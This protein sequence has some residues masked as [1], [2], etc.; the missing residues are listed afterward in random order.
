[1]APSIRH[2][3]RHLERRQHRKTIPHISRVHQTDRPSSPTVEPTRSAKRSPNH[4]SYQRGRSPKGRR[5]HPLSGGRTRG[6]R[7]QVQRRLFRYREPNTPQQLLRLFPPQVRRRFRLSKPLCRQFN[8]Q[9]FV[10]QRLLDTLISSQSAPIIKG[11]PSYGLRALRAL[12]VLEFIRIAGIREA[13]AEE[14]QF[15]EEAPPGPGAAMRDALTRAAPSETKE[16][17]VTAGKPPV[18]AFL[19]AMGIAAVGTAVLSSREAA[20]ASAEAAETAALEAAS[21]GEAAQG[22]GRAGSPVGGDAES[23]GSLRSGSGGRGSG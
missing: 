3:Y 10:V 16:K 2:A 8:R 13:R 15:P 11:R 4:F 17:A 20:A 22:S 23:S 7:R 1:M 14:S 9:P 6:G 19:K 5:R 18:G 21:A 12:W